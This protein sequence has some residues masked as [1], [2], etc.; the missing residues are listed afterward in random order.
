MLGAASG[1]ASTLPS[2]SAAAATS[3]CST[4][5]RTIST[6]APCE[7]SKQ[8]LIDFPGCA[9]V[10]SHDRFFLDRI[11]THLLV[12]EYGKSTWFEGNFADYEEIVLAQDPSHA[13]HRRS[14]YKRLTL[15]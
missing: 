7:C 11:C 5:P 1:T 4:S 15:R 6:W 12:M 2:C 3:C 8:G 13:G 9:M 10:I 14:K